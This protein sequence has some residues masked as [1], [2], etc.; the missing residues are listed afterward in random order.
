MHSS[1]GFSSQV[2]DLWNAKGHGVT[3][4]I[5]LAELKGWTSLSR[6]HKK[7]SQSLIRNILESK[8]FEPSMDKARSCK[9]RFCLMCVSVCS[10]NTRAA[11]FPNIRKGF[12]IKRRNLGW[13]SAFWLLPVTWYKISDFQDCSKPSRKQIKLLSFSTGDGSVFVGASGRMWCQGHESRGDEAGLR[14]VRVW[15]LKQE[16]LVSPGA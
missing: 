1:G 14:Q 6:G 16:W 8:T 7:N 5:G 15:L 2:Q 4:R 12:F 9:T 11:W 10:I 13:V 3:C